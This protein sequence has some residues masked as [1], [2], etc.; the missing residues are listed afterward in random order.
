[1]VCFGMLGTCLWCPGKSQ[2]HALSSMILCL[3]CQ[4]F[5][6]W[7]RLGICLW[8]QWQTFGK[9][10]SS[11]KKTS[12]FWKVKIPV[13]PRMSTASYR[14]RRGDGSFVTFVIDL[15]GSKT[16]NVMSQKSNHSNLF[17]K[18]VSSRDIFPSAVQP[19]SKGKKMKCKVESNFMTFFW[20]SL[21]GF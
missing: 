8:F 2:G 18:H 1:M 20:R 12:S 5:S 10:P 7:I 14:A 6:T 11:R 19:Y 9:A 13:A 4:D 21:L 16:W 17:F 3:A 15:E